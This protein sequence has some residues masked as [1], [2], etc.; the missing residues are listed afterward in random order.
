M[1]KK[2][3]LST[4]TIHGEELQFVQ[5]AFDRNWV[6]PLG[7]NCDGFETETQ[8]YLNRDGRWPVHALALCSGTAAIHLAVKLAGVKPGDPVLCSDLT[9][10][11][12][13]N[14][15]T[16]EGGVPVFV[17]SE[18]DTWNMDP[19]ALELAFQRHPGA[20]VVVMAHLFG[21]PGKMDELLAVC[22]KH[23]AVLIEDAAEAFAADYRGRPCGTF[24]EYGIL[25]FNGNKIITT[26]GGGMLLCR[27]RG[28][29]DKA[30]FW[31]TQAREKEIWY[32]HREIGYNYRM[33]NVV[34][35]IGR[36]QLLH[37]EEHRGRKEA[38]YRRYQ[39]GLTELPVTMNPWL[40]DTRPNFWL[41][42]LTMDPDWGLD[43]MEVVRKLGAENVEARPIWKP[44]HLQPIFRDRDFVK[45]RERSVGEDIFSRGICLPSDIKMTPQE[46]D[47]VIELLKKIIRREA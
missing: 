44:M 34:A 6:A 41:S 21:T 35:G 10:A 36:G 20:R 31:A 28:D 2:I 32:E 18:P 42:C 13:V 1:E 37:L 17:D 15:V 19:E 14:P 43:P 30:L 46:Q 8:Q 9:F 7:F 27:D 40:P 38:I 39:A 47:R 11:A 25:S 5:E 24:G 12:T 26:S 4:P 33:S 22:Q 23:G 16:Y 45:V 3:P 29:R